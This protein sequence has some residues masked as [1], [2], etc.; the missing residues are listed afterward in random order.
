V[1]TR[2]WASRFSED[3]TE[4]ALEYTQTVAVDERL[5][6]P[7][8]WA[9]LAHL[10]MLC[11]QGIVDA[12]DGRAIARCL[13][14]MTE[15]A[16]RG[17]L[18]L[19]RE[20]EDVH[21]NLEALLIERT[22]LEV[23][24]RLHTAR[25]RNDQVVTDARIHVRDALLELS[26]AIER[27]GRV[28]LERAEQETASVML[29]Y[30]HSQAA[31]PITF[32]FWLTCSASVAARDLR[33]VMA[34]YAAVDECP[35][36]AG[37]LAGTSFDTDRALTCR[38]LGFERVMTHALDATTSRDFVLETLATLALVMSNHSRL[39]EELVTRTGLCDRTLSLDDAV[40]TG[41]SIMPQK[42][43][44]VIAELGRARAGAVAAALAEVLAVVK[45]VPF[46]YSCDLQEDKPALW[47]ALDATLATTTML[48]GHLACVQLDRERAL[49]QCWESFCTATELA[50]SLVTRDGLP[51]RR[52]YQIVGETVQ[53]LIRD[54]RGLRDTSHVATLLAAHGVERTGEEIFSIVDPEAVVRRQRSAGSTGPVAVRELIEDLRGDF[55]A[56]AYWRLAKAHALQHA[57]STTLS[58]A[59]S[60]AS[61]TDLDALLAAEA[62]GGATP[63]PA[64]HLRPG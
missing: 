44:P 49:Q 1:T 2:L 22:G 36:G 52:A 34:T 5:L 35:L 59:E 8:L 18:R 61:G 38:L 40:A 62:T 46:G 45:A 63:M 33:R 43:N 14:T 28:A 56:C 12:A 51:F 11:G 32:G 57:R 16:Q 20:L 6:E 25:S 55:D 53:D 42:K 64:V 15:E 10:L 13:L 27:L 9:S 17:E 7:E 39:C 21:L 31:Q 37:A 30:T 41:S 50:N 19:A 3:L 26:A 23:G 4:E 54:G 24:G 60:F 48:T 29:G 47:R 58:I